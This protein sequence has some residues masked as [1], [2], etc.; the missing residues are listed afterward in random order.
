MIKKVFIICSV[1]LLLG[2]T[3]TF[4]WQIA[5]DPASSLEM[6]YETGKGYGTTIK[7]NREKI[8]VAD[9]ES[10][11]YFLVLEGDKI[12]AYVIKGEDK[13]LVKS[14]NPDPGFVE[15]SELSKLK[16]GIYASTYDELCLYLESYIS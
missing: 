13:K 1:C 8:K 7:Q 6:E 11:K 16:N 12:C 5:R 14:T 2:V 4:I 10:E 3:F 15:E 9:S